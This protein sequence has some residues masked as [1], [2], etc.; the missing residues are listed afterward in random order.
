MTYQTNCDKRIDVLSN[1]VLQLVTGMTLMKTEL[2][3]FAQLMTQQMAIQQS[4][5]PKG[6][7]QRTQ[8][9]QNLFDDLLPGVDLDAT[10]TL[11]SDDDIQGSEQAGEHI[12]SDDTEFIGPTDL[13]PLFQQADSFD[14]VENNDSFPPDTNNPST[15]NRVAVAAAAPLPPSPSH[16]NGPPSSQT[17]SSP[18]LTQ[19]PNPRRNQNSIQSYFPPAPLNSRN[20]NTP[21]SAGAEV[22]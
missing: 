13:D 10:M 15:P 1:N 3:R 14:L 19:L 18:V 6:R 7:K 20:T 16:V 8:G 22:K 9:H 5:G 2:T 21:D 11:E 4:P 12:M 17:T